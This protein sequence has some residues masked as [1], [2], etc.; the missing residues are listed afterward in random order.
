MSYFRTGLEPL[1]EKIALNIGPSTAV[2]PEAMHPQY[3]ERAARRAPPPTANRGP[4]QLGGV[5]GLTPAEEAHATRLRGMTPEQRRQD[6]GLPTTPADQRQH[7]IQHEMTRA[8]ANMPTATKPRPTATGPVP[9]G[10]LQRFGQGAKRGVKG[11]ALGTG[12]ALGLG[13]LGTGWALNKQ[14]EEDAR[15]RGVAY[16][17]MQGTI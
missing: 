6:F 17:P 2:H 15:N 5:M 8:D 14:H 12:V 9:P 11:L 4:I 13:A 10:V 1:L 16:A 3:A 7:A